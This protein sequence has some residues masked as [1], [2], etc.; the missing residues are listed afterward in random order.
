[1]DRL[2]NMVSWR[3]VKD[4]DQRSSE[5]QG[6]GPFRARAELEQEERA[7]QRKLELAV[8]RSEQNPPAVRI[9]AWE[10]LH[11]LK[12]PLDSAHPILGVIAVGTRLT[13]AEIHAEQFARASRPAA[14]PARDTPAD[15]LAKG[16][17][18][19]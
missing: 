9:R 18:P 3:Q 13:L 10:R 19:C 15:A 14:P 16:T 12:L 1:M 17:D 4:G 5:M 6:P 7:I 2:K 11:G 8:Q